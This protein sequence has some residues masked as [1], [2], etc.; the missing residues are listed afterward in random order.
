MG[1]ASGPGIFL[2]NLATVHFYLIKE[3][4]TSGRK[5]GRIITHMSGTDRQP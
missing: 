1:V 5:T 4:F 3:S 2:V